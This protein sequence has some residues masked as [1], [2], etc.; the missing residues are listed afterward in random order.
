M[1]QQRYY[2]RGARGQ[3]QSIV[4]RIGN[5]DTPLVVDNAGAQWVIQSPLLKRNW[6]GLY[7]QIRESGNRR[8]DA[9]Q[10]LPFYNL[11]MNNQQ[12]QDTMDALL[13]LSAQRGRW[14]NNYPVQQ[15][16]RSNN[17]LWQLYREAN[18]AVLSGDQNALV[19]VLYRFLGI[20]E[21]SVSSSFL[22]DN[23]GRGFG[24]DMRVNIIEA[25]L[26][27]MP[28]VSD[29]AEP[30]Y[31][32]YFLQLIK[33]ITR[34][35]RATLRRLLNAC[36]AS[37]KLELFDIAHMILTQGPNPRL[38]PDGGIFLARQIEGLLGPNITI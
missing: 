8:V 21:G 6:P 4:N 22:I 36:T 35:D 37:V 20:L 11:P 28:I 16:Q 23:E 13:G 25:S 15:W 19:N 33:N 14:Y 26:H 1:L 30:D 38:V 17:I 9:Q 24:R 18:T 2:G 5:S 7:H 10:L 12:A 3:R 27:F 34:G 32:F 31:T 29:V